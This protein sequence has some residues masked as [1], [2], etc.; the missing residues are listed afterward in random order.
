VQ[1]GQVTGLLDW[2]MSHPGHPYDDLAVAVWS[3]LGQL[4]PELVV[5]GYERVGGAAVDRDLLD[6]FEVLAG[7]TRA[8][9]LALGVADY[10]EGRISAPATAG[11]GLELLA[12]SLERAALA[13]GWELAK[14]PDLQALPPRLTGLRPTPAEADLGVARL[15][16][17][18]VL[19]VVD[20]A[21]TRRLLK[22][23][24]ALLESGAERTATAAV[25]EGWRNAEQSTLLSRLRGAGVPAQDLETAATA[26]ERDDRF[27]AMRAP[28]R[29][30][31]LQDLAAERSAFRPLRKL[32]GVAAAAAPRRGELKT[33]G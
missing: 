11:L 22:H 28:V 13:A 14:P 10:I 30:Y 33:G 1:D 31:L 27:E 17:N 16:L 5:E 6:W 3:C 25:I 2:E 23:A 15:L 9:A 7:V 29:R 12:A 18:E 32:Y 20:D 24:A 4:D 26:V 19:P 8:I 21:H